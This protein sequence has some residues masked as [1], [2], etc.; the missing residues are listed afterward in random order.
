MA[1]RSRLE[2]IA[3]TI[4]DLVLAAEEK[5]WE[6]REMMTAGRPGAGIYLTGY[7]AE[8]LLKTA[9]FRVDG[10]SLGDP[11]RPRLRPARRTGSIAFPSVRDE[12]YHSLLFWCHL[13]LYWRRRRPVVAWD[14]AF[15]NDF[16]RRVR[17]LYSMWWVEMRYRPDQTWPA[18]AEDV[19][20]LASWVR[21][22][23]PRLWR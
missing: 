20:D 3:E 11:V 16:L 22:N 13:L 15:R 9:V 7:A 14:P 18:E 17:R 23:Y 2:A 8:M 19:L 12:G 6:S 4:N 21:A 5:Y 10:A 1:L